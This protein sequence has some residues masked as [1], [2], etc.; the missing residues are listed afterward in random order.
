V[1]TQGVEGSIRTIVFG[2]PMIPLQFT[3][4]IEIYLDENGVP[5]NGQMDPTRLLE[6][7]DRLAGRTC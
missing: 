4:D 5:E 2:I 6:I 7:R 1:T 3:Q